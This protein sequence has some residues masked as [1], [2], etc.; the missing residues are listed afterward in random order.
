LV[1]APLQTLLVDR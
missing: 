1:R